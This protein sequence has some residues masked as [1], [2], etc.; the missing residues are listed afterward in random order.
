MMMNNL[1]FY[2]F[3]LRCV[4]WGFLIGWSDENR[5]KT[6]TTNHRDTIN[7]ESYS[8]VKDDLRVVQ[9]PPRS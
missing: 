9:T 3:F 2:D 4:F 6:T 8:R 5:A 7:L 1:S